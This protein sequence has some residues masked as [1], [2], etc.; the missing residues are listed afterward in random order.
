MFDTRVLP[1]GAAGTGAKAWV[2]PGA[3]QIAGIK[4][5]NKS[6]SWLVLPD[7]AF[8]PP[9]TLGW[10]HSFQPTLA[11]IDVLFSGGP[12]GQVSTNQGDD[13]VVVIYSDPVGESP[14]I[15]SGAGT[16]FV[17]QFTPVQAQAIIQPIAQSTGITGQILFLPTPGK[18]WRLLTL[19]VF[20]GGFTSA[21]PAS[22]PLDVGVTYYINASSTGLTQVAGHVDPRQPTDSKN[23]P[24]G[25]DFPVGDGISYDA[26]VDWPVDTAITI[27]ATAMLI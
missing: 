16:A 13:P 23:Y 3:Y 6:G 4:V 1:I 18:R 7:G 19:D 8:I 14:G 25:L 17:E 10:G 27:A 26:Q 12:A 24:N 15:P 2:L 9:Y 11:S 21:P 5:D 20:L 22:T